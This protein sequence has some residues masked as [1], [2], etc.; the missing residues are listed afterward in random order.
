VLQRLQQTW[1]GHEGSAL[2]TT[3]QTPCTPGSGL[4]AAAAAA[5]PG[6]CRTPHGLLRRKVPLKVLCLLVVEVLCRC[7]GADCRPTVQW[8]NTSMTLWGYRQAR[9]VDLTAG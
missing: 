6:S 3:P 1:P 9:T 8:L 4:A 7:A 2:S 5:T